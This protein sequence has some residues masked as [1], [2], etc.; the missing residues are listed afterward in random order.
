MNNTLI[1]I[2][3]LLI[4]FVIS[5]STGEQTALNDMYTEWHP[6]GWSS[7][8]GCSMNG[9]L[10]INNRVTGLFVKVLKFINN[11]IIKGN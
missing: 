11:L 2:I 8:P 5:L 4:P 7:S 3:T 6:H 1:F 10:C 9:I